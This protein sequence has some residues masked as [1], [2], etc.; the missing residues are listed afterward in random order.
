MR[1]RFRM[2]GRSSACNRLDRRRFLATCGAA[3][4][5]VQCGRRVDAPTLT[6]KWS[7]AGLPP[8]YVERRWRADVPPQLRS[9][10]EGFVTRAGF[11]NLPEDLGGNPPDGRD[12]GTYSI[13]VLMGTR[14]H[15]VRF[16]DTSQTPE[17]AAFRAW[18][19][20]NLAPVA[21]VE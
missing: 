5:L 19:L 17:L 6:V 14:M 10:A 4:G 12:M 8:A 11:F 1:T 20:D 18:I 2:P 13:T 3:V 16:S 15:T 21:V 9:A 7:T